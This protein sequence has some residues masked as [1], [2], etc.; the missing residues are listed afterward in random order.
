M[1][2]L[3]T[4]SDKGNGFAILNPFDCINKVRS[5]LDDLSKFC[6]LN[7]DILEVCCK[8]EHKLVR[9]FRD[10]L[11]NKKYITEEVYDNFILRVLPLAFVMVFLKFTNL[12]AVA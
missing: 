9:L 10:S 12:I 6:E 4:R 2:L 3:I 11:L 8:S 5:I 7:T 1:D